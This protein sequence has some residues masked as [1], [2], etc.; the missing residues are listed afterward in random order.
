MQDELFEMKEITYDL[1]LSD[2]VFD[3]SN[4]YNISNNCIGYYKSKGSRLKSIRY[5]VMIID[6]EKRNEQTDEKNQIEKREYELEIPLQ[7][8]ISGCM[9]QI[10]IDNK[11]YTIHIPPG[12]Q[13]YSFF[14][15]DNKVK[16]IIKYEID[17]CYKR[18]GN[19]LHGY[20]QYEKQYENMSVK[21][22]YIDGNELSCEI[23]LINGI[24]YV[25]DDYGFYDITT[26]QKGKY[27]IH[28][29]LL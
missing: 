27:F 20:F 16:V 13:E 18:I 9:K 21:P 25:I 26:G 19:D 22:R 12:L 1:N 28:F 11:L 15:F 23:Q 29:S 3:I 24:D 5:D 7:D 10:E 8:I 2:D 14:E 17:N 4:D 6:N